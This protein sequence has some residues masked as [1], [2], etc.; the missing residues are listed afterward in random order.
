MKIIMEG[1]NRFNCLLQFSNIYNNSNKNK[2]QNS[3]IKLQ[4]IAPK[5]IIVI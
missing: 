3:F 5:T 1:R 4:S 2:I